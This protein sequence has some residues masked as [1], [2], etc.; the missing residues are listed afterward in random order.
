[1]NP[2]RSPRNAAMDLLA[3]REHARSELERKLSRHFDRE[4]IAQALDR[5]AE[6]GLQSDRRFAEAFVRERATRGYGPQRI[7]AELQ[8]RGIADRVA[9]A[10]LATV[11][12]EE[13]IDWREQARSA[14]CKKFG[15]ATL[16]ADFRERA[17]RLRFLSY[18]GFDTSQFAAASD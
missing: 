10:A 6:E 18:R 8:Q 12:E 13:G 9:Q 16:P 3:R 7:N 11:C 14:L 15:Q 17:R 1:M 5:L 2:E 4:A